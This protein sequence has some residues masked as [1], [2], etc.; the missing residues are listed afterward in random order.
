[1]II[2]QYSSVRYD[3]HYFGLQTNLLAALG[4]LVSFC[5]ALP[6]PLLLL[7]PTNSSTKTFQDTLRKLTDLL[8]RKRDQ[9]KKTKG[10][11]L[12]SLRNPF[13]PST[14]KT[15][16][17]SSANPHCYL[18]QAVVITIMFLASTTMLSTQKK[19]ADESVPE[20]NKI[21]TIMAYNGRSLPGLPGLW[22]GAAQTQH[23]LASSIA[24]LLCLFLPLF[25]INRRLSFASIVATSCLTIPLGLFYVNLSFY[26]INWLVL[27]V[28]P[29]VSSVSL[30]LRGLIAIVI[31]SLL[32]ALT[33]ARFEHFA[34]WNEKEKKNTPYWTNS[35]IP[36]IILAL[37]TV[38]AAVLGSVIISTKLMMRLS[39]IASEL[40]SKKCY[41]NSYDCD[42]Y[43][44]DHY[45]PYVEA[46]VAF[47]TFAMAHIALS[48]IVM[49]IA[50]LVFLLG[51]KI[52]GLTSWMLGSTAF[53]LT[54][55][56]IVYYALCL[57]RFMEPLQFD[58]FNTEFIFINNAA[59]GLLVS[60]VFMFIGR[61]S[62]LEPLSLILHFLLSLP[63]YLRH[64]IPPFPSSALVSLPSIKVSISANNVLF[65]LIC[66][67]GPRGQEECGR[68]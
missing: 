31:A 20:Y 21:L 56:T 59:L 13:S 67:A 44:D 65:L 16:L 53:G 49:V 41:S 55:A 62:C 14:F 18:Q 63:S 42:Y 60:S 26:T 43:Y 28:P 5:L 34:R 47:L 1:M 2:L 35:R 4:L 46:I 6:W 9:V 8:Q 11:S 38:F 54:V 29:T 40:Q 50:F 45:F 32:F 37:V 25:F 52:S 19:G 64:S 51:H 22:L 39:S 36:T 48:M 12:P 15:S 27:L 10:L 58:I 68:K 33:L 61:K 7:W 57:R 17:P 23:R 3:H 24:F 66:V 30:V